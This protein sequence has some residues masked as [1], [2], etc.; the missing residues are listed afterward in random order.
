MPLLC[1]LPAGD[2]PRLRAR[3]RGLFRKIDETVAVGGVQLL[4]Q[5][6]HNGSAADVCGSVPRRK[7]HPT[8]KLHCRH[9]K[10][11]A[12]AVVSTRRGGHRSPTPRASATFRRRRGDPRRPCASCCTAAAER[13]R[14]KPDV[15]RGHR[16]RTADYGDDV[17][18]DG[19]TDE[20][21]RTPMRCVCRMR[22]AV[23]RVHHLGYQPHTPS[24]GQ[25]APRSTTC[26]PRSPGS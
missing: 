11:S 23:H 25:R 10:F 18:A 24:G 26:E 4:L 6:G 7:A 2:H 8:F 3:I 9:R 20:T 1:V 5:G 13:R 16:S 21:A 15:M 19:E 12:S 14:T 17:L 22:P